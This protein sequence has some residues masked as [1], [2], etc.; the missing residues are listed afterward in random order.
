MPFSEAGVSTTLAPRNRISRRR[1]TEK[2]SAIV[3]TSGYPFWAQ[4]MAR[5]IPVLPLV[6]STT[7]WPGLRCPLFSASSIT[8]MASLSLTEPIGLKDSSLA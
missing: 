2:F 3:T 5:P 1:S 4:T 7:V 8:P 6:A